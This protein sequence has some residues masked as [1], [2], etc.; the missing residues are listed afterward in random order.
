MAIL[1]TYDT[2]TDLYRQMYA[3]DGTEG[4]RFDDR[5]KVL[6]QYRRL[7]KNH[8]SLV[9]GTSFRRPTA[10]ENSR[11]YEN[12]LGVHQFATEHTPRN[13]EPYTVCDGRY[14]IG[15]AI[16]SSSLETALI[17]A[18]NKRYDSVIN[19]NL[20]NLMTSDL[21]LGLMAVGAK[22]SFVMVANA[23]T[24][25]R[26]FWKDLKRGNLQG[27]AKAVG[28]KP[29]KW[30][31]VPRDA[32]DRYLEFIFGWQQ[33]LSDAYSAVTEYN[34]IQDGPPPLLTA[35]THESFQLEEIH[36]SRDIRMGLYG[37]NVR[38]TSKATGEIKILSRFDTQ[39]SSW[40]TV[41]ANRLGLLNPALIAW[42]LV[43]YSFVFDWFYPV[44]SYLSAFTA[45]AGL[46]PLGSSHT[47]Y[48]TGQISN[49]LE[50]LQYDQRTRGIVENSDLPSY[51]EPVMVY[52]RNAGGGLPSPVLPSP[53]YP[54]S[55][56]QAITS[57][58]LV[59][60]RIFR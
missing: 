49:T 15:S 2:V 37:P 19:R 53:R 56:S 21:N 17:S 3:E 30:T 31:N 41:I 33:L 26:K 35:R 22:Q 51:A 28:L 8:G 36:A 27:A 40:N 48:C 58:A 23:A 57:T 10:Y 25:V 50:P 47:I 1:T 38:V 29:S 6:T 42:D 39:I 44:G 46:R 13:G 55:L 4:R 34:I 11:R 9:S 43:P 20:N 32:S 12:T 59:A 16:A 14:Y 54:T 7:S 5:D 45:D 52:K 18:C 24:G 60:Q